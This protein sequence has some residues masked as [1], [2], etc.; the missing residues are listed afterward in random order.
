MYIC[1]DDEFDSTVITVDDI[2][3][4]GNESFQC[5]STK[6]TLN[7]L[8]LPSPLAYLLQESDNYSETSFHL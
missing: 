4:H 1:L 6:V 5:P 2:S 7:T 3:L 8:F